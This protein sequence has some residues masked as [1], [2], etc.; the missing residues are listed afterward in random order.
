VDGSLTGGDQKKPLEHVGNPPRTVLRMNLLKVHHPL[1]DFGRYPALTANVSLRF[2]TL[3]S[4]ESVDPYPALDRMA[5]N[6]KLLAKQGCAVTFLQ[7]K[8]YHPQPELH[9]VS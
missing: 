8:P 5:A 3:G 1:P 9:G 4:T 6:P 2:Q 7:E